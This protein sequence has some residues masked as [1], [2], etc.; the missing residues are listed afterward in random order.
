MDD[1]GDTNTATAQPDDANSQSS[2]GMPFSNKYKLF[3]LHIFI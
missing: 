3:Q 1:A 2:D